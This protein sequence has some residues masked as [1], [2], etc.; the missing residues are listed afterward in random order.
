AVEITSASK[1]R[2][3]PITR[4]NRLRSRFRDIAIYDCAAEITPKKETP[5]V[6]RV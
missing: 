2:A 4:I 1:T 5:P 6:G 3:K